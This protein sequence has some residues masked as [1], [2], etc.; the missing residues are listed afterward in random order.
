MQEILVWLQLLN[1]FVHLHRN[2]KNYKY[3]RNYYT[4]ALQA[5]LL[6]DSAKQITLSLADAEIAQQVM[7]PKCKSPDFSIPHWSSSVKFGITGYYNPD[8]LQQAG[9]QDT[10]LSCHVLIFTFCCTTCCAK[11]HK[12]NNASKIALLHHKR[13]DKVSVKHTPTR[14]HSNNSLVTNRYFVRVVKKHFYG[15]RTVKLHQHYN[16]VADRGK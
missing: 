9:S 13:E 12:S 15:G 7:L 8:Q 3:R 5:Y 10:N 2:K 16:A 1:N 6:E 4:I 11:K 14:Q